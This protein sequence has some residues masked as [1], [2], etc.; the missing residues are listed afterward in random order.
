M[1]DQQNYRAEIAGLFEAAEWYDRT[2]D[3]S[4]RIAREVPVL[5]DVLGPPGE[6]GILDAGCGTGHQARSLCE[7]GYRVVGADSSEE[8]LEAARRR[9]PPGARQPIVYVCASYAALYDAVGGGFDGLYCVGNALAA[10]GTAEAS[11]QAIDQF[12]ACLR[13]GG[14][15]FL[16]VLNFAPMRLER[17]CIRGPRVVTTDGIEYISLRHFHFSEE[18]AHVTGIS[19]YRDSGW[20]QRSHSGRLYPMSLDELRTWCG[21]AG[22]RID[23]EW[24]SYAREPFDLERSVDLII[25][26]TRE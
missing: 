5:I 4:A 24:G 21:E 20:R 22:L 26:A 2:I 7:R 9:S 10:A 16:Q 6:G 14:G 12:S 25:A 3:W 8:M 1:S 11:S 13:P 19:I 17:P 15:L 18:C 23:A